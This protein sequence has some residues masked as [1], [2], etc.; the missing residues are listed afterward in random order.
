MDKASRKSIVPLPEPARNFSVR[1]ISA[2]IGPII[3]P[4]LKRRAPTSY[5]LL[6]DWEELAGP[7][8]AITARP[9]KLAGGTLT[10]ACSGPVAMEL[11]YRS[12]ALMRRL[13][14]GL[15]GT[16]VERLKFVQE[17]IPEP[18]PTR[19][20]RS[21]TAASAPPAGLSD[22]PLGAA[23]AKLYQGIMNKGE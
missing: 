23:L 22:D 19:P 14:T 16:V 1:G 10:L 20:A 15:S 18:S 13:N 5:Q 2:L 21:K 7:E 11:Q 12:D 4:S 3:R 8:F 17:I 6:L 9:M